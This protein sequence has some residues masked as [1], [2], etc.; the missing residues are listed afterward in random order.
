MPRGAC[1]DAGADAPE[2]DLQ[3]VHSLG[4][5]FVAIA[6]SAAG[7]P[8]DA[9]AIR[10]AHLR[11]ALTHILCNGRGTPRYPR[12]IAWIEATFERL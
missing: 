9:A 8:L 2:I 11:T 7:R 6:T 10:R 12:I 5:R 3:Y 1:S 4:P